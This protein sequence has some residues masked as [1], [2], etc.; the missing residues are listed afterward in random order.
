M[1][2]SR[3]HSRSQVDDLAG[4]GRA[5][6]LLVTWLMADFTGKLEIVSPVRWRSSWSRIALAQAG[7]T[8][9]RFGGRVQA[10]QEV[11][12]GPIQLIPS[13]IWGNASWDSCRLATSKA[14]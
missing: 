4:A 14:R 8:A 7:T 2:K 6:R 9:T 3:W 11:P 5:P 12:K 1:Q 13:R 10:F